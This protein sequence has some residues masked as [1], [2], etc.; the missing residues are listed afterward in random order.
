MRSC[1][2]SDSKPRYGI[3]STEPAIEL[4]RTPEYEAKKAGLSTQRRLLLEF[5]EEGIAAD[6]DRLG[7]RKD[8]SDLGKGV[9]IDVSEPYLMVAFRR[10]DADHGELIAFRFL[11]D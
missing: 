10:I 3:R 9:V 5:V 4:T 6:P 8:Q 11:D 1:A 2:R 7:F